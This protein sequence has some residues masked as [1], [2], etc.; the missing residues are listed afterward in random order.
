VRWRRRIA[1]AG[2]VEQKGVAD[3][4]REACFIRSFRRLDLQDF[5]GTQL[6]AQHRLAG[7]RALSVQGLKAASHQAGNRQ[8]YE[9]A[10]QPNLLT[11][12]H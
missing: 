11:P 3:L 1:A 7:E 5:D 6:V 4:H 8:Q 12:P 2:K 10:G 9:R